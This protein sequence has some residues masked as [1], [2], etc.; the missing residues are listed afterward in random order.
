[1]APSSYG[2]TCMPNNDRT[3]ITP[4]LSRQMFNEN[5]HPSLACRGR[6]NQYPVEDVL[7]N[8]EVATVRLGQQ[9][10]PHAIVELDGL[11]RA[12]CLV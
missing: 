3:H 11:V 8:N 1:M 9:R 12:C 6:S 5:S 10:V 4:T 7:E 2:G